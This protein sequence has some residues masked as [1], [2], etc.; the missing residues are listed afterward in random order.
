VSNSNG[1]GITQWGSRGSG[2]GQF[3]EPYGVALDSSD[4]VYVAD[5]YNNRIQKF[6]SSGK[7]ITKWGS[8]GS[9]DGE[10]NGPE[11]VAVD[12]SGNV[13]VADM[14]NN[15]IQV[16]TSKVLP[17]ANFTSNVSS[18]YAPLSVQFTD[19]STNATGWNWDFGDGNISYIKN[20]VHTFYAVRDYTINLTVNNTNGTD[21]KLATINVS[22]KPIIPTFPGYSNPPT[23]PNHDGLYEDIN[24]NSHIDF[25]DVVAYYK[26]MNWI[27][28][29]NLTKYFDYNRNGQI[30]FDDVVKLYDM[31]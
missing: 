8:S 5:S 17:V 4:N 29:N 27:E 10:F 18:G 9:G 15:R 24:G 7:F 16:F 1:V 25:D 12:S 20:P 11:S 19:L 26:N 13:Y 23:D 14:G 2:D 31:L 3:Y 6:T 21:S 30:D 22:A 28:Q